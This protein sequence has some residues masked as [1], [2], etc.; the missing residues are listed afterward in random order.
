MN[1]PWQSHLLGVDRLFCCARAA[2]GQAAEAVVALMKSR[3][4]IAFP[5]AQD[6][7]KSV[8]ITAGIYDQ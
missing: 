2:S 7:A 6:H 4:R 1:G 3:R 8:L 5:Q